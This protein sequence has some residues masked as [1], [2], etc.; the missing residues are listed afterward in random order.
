[1]CVY[2]VTSYY[3]RRA[4]LYEV[5]CIAL[6]GALYIVLHEALCIV[7]HETLRIALHEMLH[8]HYTLCGYVPARGNVGSCI[9]IVGLVTH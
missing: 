4:V 1:M 6:H 9:Y 3:C 5:F 2:T 8:V 7:L